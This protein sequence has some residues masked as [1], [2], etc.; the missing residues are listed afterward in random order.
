MVN[1]SK[2]EVVP[3]FH[4]VGSSLHKYVIAFL[5][6]LPEGTRVALDARPKTMEAVGSFRN[7]LAGED[8]HA[9]DFAHKTLDRFTANMWSV[10][11]IL[12]LCHRRKLEVIPLHD[13]RDAGGLRSLSERRAH[14]NPEPDPSWQVPDT[15][16]I[17]A[18]VELNEAIEGELARVI[19]NL[20]R[21]PS[22]R[23]V[24]LT[25]P[26]HAFPLVKHLTESG[27]SAGVESKCFRHIWNNVRTYLT[28]DVA[29]RNAVK[30]EM[31]AKMIE[32]SGRIATWLRTYR[33]KNSI[34]KI[35]AEV[36]ARIAHVHAFAF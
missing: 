7:I 30:A 4:D 3:Y 2:V 22:R 31:A 14:I 12:D 20:P 1:E 15:P 9:L 11:D 36:I 10:F 27:V 25:A 32:A 19:G 29:M 24:V 5:S 8:V 23:L 35:G 21:D 33:R 6:T 18:Y 28:A 34:Q 16:R 17:R 13:S 26:E